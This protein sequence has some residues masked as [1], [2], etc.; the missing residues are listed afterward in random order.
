[1]INYVILETEPPSL[2]LTHILTIGLSPTWIILNISFLIILLL[3]SALISGSEIAFFSLNSND[4]TNLNEENSKQ[5]KLILQL[6]EKPGKL[7]ATILISNNLVNI[8]IVILSTFVLDQFFSQSLYEQLGQWFVD[9]I[10]T[11]FEIKE[12][13]G[14]F[15]LLINV[16]AVTFLLVLF[17]EVAPKIY[18]NFNNVN[19]AKFMSRPLYFLNKVFGPIS[20][21][22]VNWTNILEKRF[23]DKSQ[24]KSIKEDID[25]AIELTINNEPYQENEADILRGILNFSDLM[26]RQIMCPRTDV[27]GFEINGTYPELIQIIKESGYSRIPIFEDDF[28]NV[29]GILYIKDLISHLEENE[30]FNWTP[31]IRKD[32]L[33]VPEL[34]K[35]NELLKEFQQKRM[36]M[37]IVVDEYG[38]SSGIVTLEDVMEEIVGEI[39]D[40]FDEDEDVEYVKIDDSNYIFDAKTNL[41]DAARITELDVSVF[42]DSR[43]DADTLAGLMLEILGFIP[44]VDREI[45]VNNIKLKVVSVNKKRIE[46]ISILIT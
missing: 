19:F 16:V 29:I 15:N 12:I 43:G 3:A 2:F 46:K 24:K 34:K 14:F 35:V 6:L 25:Q 33:Y 21:I 28:D 22:L 20:N 44:K 7:L 36:H 27:V 42:E 9:N 30:T 31:L 8:G 37:A 45:Q 38:G 40:E 23:G 26:V 17:G 39:R 41:Q 5:S 18:A 11:Y 10:T 32:L 4:T 1:M 13:A